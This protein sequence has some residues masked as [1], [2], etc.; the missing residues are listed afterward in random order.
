[1]ATNNKVPN[2]VNVA[3]ECTSDSDYKNDPSYCGKEDCGGYRRVKTFNPSAPTENI[4]NPQ[5]YAK[6]SYQPQIDSNQF[7]NDPNV[8][9]SSMLNEETYSTTPLSG[10]SLLSIR[11]KFNYN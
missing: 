8:D 4:E 6:K 9:Q 3:D 5:I 10:Y 11:N 1:M 2:Y 7:I